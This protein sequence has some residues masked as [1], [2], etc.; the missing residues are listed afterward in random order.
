MLNQPILQR[1]NKSIVNR[2]NNTN[3]KKLNK[4]PIHVIKCI[5][6]TVKAIL[7]TLQIVILYDEQF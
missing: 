7:N 2:I 4:S 5:K 6:L 1:K 3:S